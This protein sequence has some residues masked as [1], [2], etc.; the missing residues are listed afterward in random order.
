MSEKKIT[1]PTEQELDQLGIDLLGT[2]EC[3]ILTLGTE[4]VVKREQ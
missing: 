1:R 4:I 3:E 2:W